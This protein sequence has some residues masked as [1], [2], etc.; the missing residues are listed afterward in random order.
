MQN[1]DI[2]GTRT[3]FRT[4]VYLEPKAHSEH[5]QTSMMKPFAKIATSYISVNEAFF[6]NISLMFQEI[7]S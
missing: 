5:C 7:T 1:P 4:L 3:T 6:P 2:L